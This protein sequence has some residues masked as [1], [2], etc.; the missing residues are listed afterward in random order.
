MSYRI[1]LEPDGDIRLCDWERYVAFRRAFAD[2]FSRYTPEEVLEWG[3]KT[4]GD[5]FFQAIA[6]T[7]M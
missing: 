3:R 7:D 1:R 6:Q 2:L 4:F 5:R